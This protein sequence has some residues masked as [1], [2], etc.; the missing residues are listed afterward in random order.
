MGH[1]GRRRGRGEGRC[2]SHSPF[3]CWVPTLGCSISARLAPAATR[4]P[5]QLPGHVHVVWDDLSVSYAS[6]SSPSPS[7]RGC[8][9]FS[10]SGHDGERRRNHLGMLGFSPDRIPQGAGGIGKRDSLIQKQKG[11]RRGFSTG[12]RAVWASWCWCRGV[13]SR[14]GSAGSASEE[15]AGEDPCKDSHV[16]RTEPEGDAHQSAVIWALCLPGHLP[17]EPPQREGSPGIR[18][19]GSY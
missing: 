4:R 5:R 2:A 19:V 15:E 8:S 16:P 6:F 11:S 17:Q 13:L 18:V 10:V 1:T 9:T 14:K 12:Q 7:S 3:P